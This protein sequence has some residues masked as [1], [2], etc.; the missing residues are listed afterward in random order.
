MF[1]IHSSRQHD[2]RPQFVYMSA[3][4]ERS[5]KRL[6]WAAVQ[7][8]DAAELESLIEREWATAENCIN[9]AGWTIAHGA[10]ECGHSHILALCARVVDLN[11]PK[12]NGLAVVHVAA[13]KGDITLLS[14]LKSLGADFEVLANRTPS[15]TEVFESRLADAAAH[16]DTL[17]RRLAESERRAGRAERRLERQ[18]AVREED[19]QLCETIG[20]GRFGVVHRARWQGVNVAVKVIS[21]D[22]S[23][24]EKDA[25]SQLLTNEARLLASVR[26]T[27]VV[28]FLGVCEKPPM[29]LMALTPDGVTLRQCLDESTAPS[30]A[31]RFHLV[32]GVCAGMA[33]LHR[34]GIL[35]LDLKVRQLPLGFRVPF[36]SHVRLIPP[37]PSFLYTAAKRT[38]RF[39]HDSKD[40]RFWTQRK[41]TDDAHH[42]DGC[43][44]GRRPGYYA[45]Q[46][47]RAFLHKANGPCAIRMTLRQA[48]RCVLLRNAGMGGVYGQS[49]VV[50]YARRRARSDTSRRSEACRCYR[51]PGRWRRLGAARCRRACR[52]L[53]GAGTR[54]ASDV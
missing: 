15:L 2:A 31:Q 25:A 38:G 16:A 4:G 34:R 3:K 30:E 44:D 47:T 9:R 23:K 37:S 39:G 48:C 46:G 26:H 6:V 32:R 49:A 54:G 24:V 12:K 52:G 27:N 40:R 13:A 43:A 18:W 7:R 33:A 14:M 53:L 36:L 19:V 51:T 35:H 45:V 11:Q 20:R 17:E 8:G 1:G 21:P 5:K 41:T 42:R 29:L 10:A 22:A 28:R 50:R